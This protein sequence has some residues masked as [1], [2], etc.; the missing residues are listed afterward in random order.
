[1]EKVFGGRDNGL[2]E[3]EGKAR[4]EG[5]G[6]ECGRMR[7]HLHPAQLPG[8]IATPPLTS[9]PWGGCGGQEELPA[10]PREEPPTLRALAHVA[11]ALPRRGH[12]PLAAADLATLLDQDPLAKLIAP[13]G[14]GDDACMCRVESALFVWFTSAKCGGMN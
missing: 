8:H 2:R 6:V 5:R 11:G 1:M 9:I 3:G 7:G 14:K 12:Q 10:D 4:I 13:D